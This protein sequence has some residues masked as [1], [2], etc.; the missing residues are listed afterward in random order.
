MAI[1]TLWNPS[2]KQTGQ[3]MSAAAIATYLAIE[4]NSKVLLMS[5]ECND[6]MLQTGFDVKNVRKKMLESIVKSSKINLDSG[7]DGLATISYSNKLSPKIIRDYTKVIFKNRLELLY[8]PTNTDRTEYK[9]ILDSYQD[10]LQCANQYYDYVIV[11]FNKGFHAPHTHEILELSDI[12]LVNLQ[13]RITKINEFIELKK[14]EK[15][16]NDRKIILLIN[17]YDYSSKYTLKN[18]SRY[19]G[20]RESIYVVPYNTLYMEAGEE[21]SI[22]DFFLKIRKVDEEDRNGIFFKEIG[23]TV[24]GIRFKLQELRMTK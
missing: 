15:V 3:T 17:Q 14:K 2:R 19:L 1:I 10:I 6:T 8:A 9:R 7:L 18:L 24:E 22:A 5:T 11:D 21:G 12:I 4:H 13:Q 20:K 16:L 23:R